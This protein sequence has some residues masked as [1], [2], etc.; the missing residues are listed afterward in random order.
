M[1]NYAI[2]Q[3]P[4]DTNEK[5]R[6]QILN[7]IDDAVYGLMMIMDGVAGTLQNDEYKV[8]IEYKIIL[9][10]N[11]EILQSI[12]TLDGDGMCMGFHGW[13]DGDFGEDDVVT[14]LL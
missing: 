11:G 4:A 8:M 2:K 3:I 12:N 10:K 1:R 14:S 7:G 6:E 9:K 5:T 13:K